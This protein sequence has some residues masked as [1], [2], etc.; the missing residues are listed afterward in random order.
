MLSG[1]MGF[2]I[3][4]TSYNQKMI[5]NFTCEPRLMPDLERMVDEVE[6]AFA[7]LLEAARKRN[8]KTA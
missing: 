2:G 5:F 7:E 6:G 8:P 1:A 4:V 3:A